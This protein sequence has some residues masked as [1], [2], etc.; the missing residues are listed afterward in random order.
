VGDPIDVHEIDEAR[1]REAIEALG[2]RYPAPRGREARTPH[3]PREHAAK[4]SGAVGRA[5]RSASDPSD[6]ARG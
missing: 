4:P 6:C 3:E 2:S 5:A 1:M